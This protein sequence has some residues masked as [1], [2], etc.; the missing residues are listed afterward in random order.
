MKKIGFVLLAIG[1][2]ILFFAAVV[3]TTVSG[4]GGPGINVANLPGTLIGAALCITGAVF[5]SGGVIVE[6]ITASAHAPRS[7]AHL[8]PKTVPDYEGEAVLSDDAYRIFL[9]RV[10]GIEKSEVFGRFICADKLFEN[11]KDAMKYAHSL[12]QD[13]IIGTGKIGLNKYS[14]EVRPN[15]T[16][17]RTDRGTVRF[18]SLAAAQTFV[19]GFYTTKK[20]EEALG[21]MM[22][23]QRRSTTDPWG[24][25]EEGS[26]PA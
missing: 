25:S 18:D 21:K 1:S 17:I 26:Q 20:E 4:F 9:A 5:Y 16:L 2:V 3:G 7:Q 6:A 15:Q 12:Y 22:A 24:A 8:I 14:Y 10:Y 19:N 11:F 13:R 23:E